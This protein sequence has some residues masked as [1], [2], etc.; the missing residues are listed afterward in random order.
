MTLKGCNGVY[1]AVVMKMRFDYCCCIRHCGPTRLLCFRHCQLFLLFL[2]FFMELTI[3]SRADAHIQ[4][5]G[6]AIMAAD[7][8]RNCMTC[9]QATWRLH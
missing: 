5:L 1:S 2:L 6:A 3:S 7:R 8:I 4:S 9:T